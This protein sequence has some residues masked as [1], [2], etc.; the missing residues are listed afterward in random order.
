MPK[1]P[2]AQEGHSYEEKE[3]HIHVMYDQKVSPNQGL[4]AMLLLESLIQMLFCAD[5]L[6]R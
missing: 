5:I 1:M 4:E 2:D 6:M 3:K